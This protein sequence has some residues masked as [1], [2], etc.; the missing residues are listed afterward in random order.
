M[1][2][3]GMRSEAEMF[4]WLERRAF[5]GSRLTKKM[6]Q[7]FARIC[8]NFARICNRVAVLGPVE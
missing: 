3:I 1:I 8:K 7:S 4:V 5:F 6:L 2:A